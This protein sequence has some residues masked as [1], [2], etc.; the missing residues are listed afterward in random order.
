M[1]FK[2]E[3]KTNCVIVDRFGPGEVGGRAPDGPPD[4]SERARG[5][6]ALT[7]HVVRPIRGRELNDANGDGKDEDKARTLT[8]P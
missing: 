1:N 8:D 4:Q 3:F 6:V 7:H 5:R 2:P